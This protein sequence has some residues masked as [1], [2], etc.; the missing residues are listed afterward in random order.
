MHWASLHLCLIFFCHFLWGGHSASPPDALGVFACVFFSGYFLSSSCVFSS[1]WSWKQCGNERRQPLKKRLEGGWGGGRSASPPDAWGV[2][3]CVVFFCHFCLLLLLL[4]FFLRDVLGSTVAMRGGNLKKQAGGGLGGGRSAPPPDALGVFAC[5]VF[6]LSFLS[7]SCVFS[8]WCSWKQCGSERRQPLKKW[9]EGGALGVFACVFF[10]GSFLSSS[11]V[12]SSWCSWKQ[13]GNER[14]QPFS[15][16]GFL[17]RR[18]RLAGDFLY[19]FPRTLAALAGGWGPVANTGRIW[20]RLTSRELYQ[21]RPQIARA[22]SCVINVEKDAA[23]NGV[24]L[25]PIFSR[26]GT[27]QW[28]SR[29]GIQQWHLAMALASIQ[30]WHPSN[31]TQQWHAWWHP[32]TALQQ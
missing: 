8:S 7:S 24:S 30:P 31:G 21:H 18:C 28:L 9:L 15:F 11:C 25:W 6:F 17:L 4:V 12:F 27:Q 1:W 16:H 32:A 19:Q 23:E 3:A 10:F 29:N 22:N 20:S 26:N 14:R 5:V 13:C 2:F